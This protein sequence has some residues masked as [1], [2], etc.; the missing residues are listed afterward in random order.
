LSSKVP[1]DFDRDGDLDVEDLDALTLATFE[2]FEQRFDLNSDARVDQGDRELWITGL[3]QTF[4]GDSDLDGQFGS[5][6]LVQVLQRGEYEDS[7][8][9]NSLWSDGDWNGDLEFNTSDLVYALQSGG[10]EQG[11]RPQTHVV[12]EP[13]T[14]AIALAITFTIGLLHPRRSH[15]RHFKAGRHRFAG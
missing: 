8:E 5:G 7:I 14:S 1:G 6:D 12:P 4:I 9:A 13:Q 2:T 10:Y 3:K 11:R 15:R